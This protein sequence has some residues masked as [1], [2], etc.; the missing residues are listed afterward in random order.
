MSVLTEQV[1]VVVF[2][3][4]FKPNLYDIQLQKITQLHGAYH[5]LMSV[6]CRQQLQSS[7]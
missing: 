2:C 3:D 7:L 5:N 6:I 1:V 4:M